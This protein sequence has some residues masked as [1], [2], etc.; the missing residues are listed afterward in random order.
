MRFLFGYLLLFISFHLQAQTTISYFDS[1][2]ESITK[3]N[4]IQYELHAKELIGDKIKYTHSKIKLQKDPFCFYNYI[5]NPDD[6]VE[7]LFTYKNKYALVNPNGFP[8][9]NLKLDPYGRLMRKNQ[10]HTLF[11]AG[12][13][14][15]KEIV[16][17]VLEL[18]KESPKK[19]ITDLGFNYIRHKKCKVLK[20]VNSDFAFSEYIV[21]DGEDI[22]IIASNF[23]LSSYV[24]LVKNNIN[25]YN[26]IDAGDKILIPNSYAEEFEIWVD[27]ESNLP[28]LQKIFVNNELIEHYEF[29]KVIINPEFSIDEFEEKN[30]EYSF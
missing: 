4:T 12:F 25:F 8:F 20:V 9:L 14:K 13:D 2:I 3:I 27:L 29:D 7:V 26:N 10:H 22:E 16:L 5:M 17:S 11:D 21:K 28:I 30:S 1:M 6:G 24:I 15:F 19:Y 18:L 23:N